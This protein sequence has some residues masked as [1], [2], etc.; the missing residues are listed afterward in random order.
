MAAV[1]AGGSLVAGLVLAALSSLASRIG[2]LRKARRADHQLRD[3]IERVAA[4]RVIAPIQ[5]ELDSYAAYRS[6]ILAA[7]G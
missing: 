2:G 6:G 7:L 5:A 1:I 3:A 4:E